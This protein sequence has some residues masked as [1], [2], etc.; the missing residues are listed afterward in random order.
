MG[1]CVGGGIPLI[2][3]ECHD[4]LRRR[5]TGIWCW[6]TVDVVALTLG[7]KMSG[8]NAISFALELLVLL[9]R[10]RRPTI[11]LDDRTNR[12]RRLACLDIPN[13]FS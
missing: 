4:V 1:G 9:L 13:P 2:D 8:S 5:S 12:D 6:L 10:R 3:S 11:A 7:R